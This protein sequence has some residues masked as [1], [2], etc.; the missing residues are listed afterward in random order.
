MVILA[1]LDAKLPKI[2]ESWPPTD[3]RLD[4]LWKLCQRCW[5]FQPS[6]RPPMSDVFQ[7]MSRVESLPEV[8]QTRSVLETIDKKANG[9]S[10]VFSV[11][12][13]FVLLIP[14]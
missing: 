4:Y 13:L 1:I 6:M 3:E 14:L 9:S 8:Y 10:E 2:P 11:S 5:A 7:Y 12:L